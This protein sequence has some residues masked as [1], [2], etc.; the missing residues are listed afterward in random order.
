[1]R[2]FGIFSKVFIYTTLFLSTVI[3]IS[4]G[5][6]Y[7]Q[8]N[9]LYTSQQ[10]QQLRRNYQS[11]YEELHESLTD[12]HQMIEIARRFS[13]GNQSFVFRI[14]DDGESPLFLS[15]AMQ[16]AEEGGTRVLFSLG[17][18]T[19]VAEA[20]E[21]TL[22]GTEFWIRLTFAFGA[23]LAIALVFAAL[24]ARQ[25]TNPLKSLVADTQKMVKLLPIDPPKKRNDEIG[26]LSIDVHNMY[27]KLKDTIMMLEDENIRRKE[28]EESQRYFFSAASHELKTPIAATRVVLE[29]M[30]AGVGDYGNHPKYLGECIKLMD[31][32][33][34]TIYEI[35][36]IV[37]L[38][39][40]YA[41]KPE[42]INL[43]HLVSEQLKTYTPMAQAETIEIVIEIPENL[44][45]HTDSRLINKALS[46]VILNAIQNTK[47]FGHIRIF[48]EDTQD[49]LFKGIRLSILNTGSIDEELLPR[50]FEPFYRM[51]KARSR[52]KGQTG[53]GLTIVKKTLDL[54]EVDF[55]LSNTKDGVL[56]WMTLPT[57]E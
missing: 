18:Y 30:L 51:D 26:D 28:M 13:D 56:F 8:F 3:A 49:N 55:G 5:L 36:D 39:G 11:L 52:K 32:Q 10:H 46:N 20:P 14:V 31:E 35:L 9:A 29:G 23:I 4:I 2:R 12:Q 37:N 50:L 22:S 27:D 24:F 16:I 15:H 34:K 45:C 21:P 57:N 17:G 53:L 6:F 41:P 43:S 47:K 33:S 38:D 40:H 19:L 54:M 48:A 44:Y 25:M 7:Q 1:M 42:K